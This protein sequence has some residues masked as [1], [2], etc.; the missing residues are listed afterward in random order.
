MKPIR[1]IIVDDEEGARESLADILNKY[2]PEV[3]VVAKAYSIAS[4]YT[5]I[6]KHQPDMV[7]L[8]IEMHFGTGFDLLEKLD[9]IHFD[10]VFVTA[11]D[12]YAIK[13]IKFSALDYLLK[14]VDIDDVKAVVKKHLEKTQSISRENHEVLKGNLDKSNPNKRLAISDNSGMTFV[15]L[16]EIVYCESDG[17]YTVIHIKD[18]PKLVASKTLGEY[19]KLLAEDGFFRMHRSYLVNLEHVD[20]IDRSGNGKAVLSTSE[21]LDISR[22][23]KAAFLS[24]FENA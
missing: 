17:N 8:D 12:Q 15:N 4:A 3:N 19:E 7:F 18:K 5:K 9:A 16:E 1:A 10:I 23:K 11:Y 14:P 20:R 24:M 2:V 13:A 22:R 6:E 21:S